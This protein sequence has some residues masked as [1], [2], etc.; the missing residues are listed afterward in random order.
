MRG[1]PG[2]RGVY[3]TGEAI[4]T[5]NHDCNDSST[6]CDYEGL[7][8]DSLALLHK[9]NGVS[10]MREVLRLQPTEP[11]LPSLRRGKVLAHAAETAEEAQ[12]RPGVKEPVVNLSPNGFW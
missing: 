8:G 2:F 4:G 10:A 9:L 3:G 5:Y 11:R 12:N 1:R 7:C 6:H